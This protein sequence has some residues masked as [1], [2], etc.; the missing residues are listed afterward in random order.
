M[1]AKTPTGFKDRVSQ[2]LLNETAGLWATHPTD[3]QR[4]RHARR[5]GAA[6]VFGLEKPATALFADFASLARMASHQHYRQELGLPVTASM[7]KPVG[8]L[9][10]T[11]GCPPRLH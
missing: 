4:I 2:S 1:E 10:K 11:A 7:L 6:G 9:I 5:L 3:A 8:E